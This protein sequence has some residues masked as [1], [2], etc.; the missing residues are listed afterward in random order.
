MPK[1]Q[2]RTT[3]LRHITQKS[4][5]LVFGI[6]TSASSLWQHCITSASSLRQHC[7]T[8]ASSLRQHCIT[9]A[10]SLWQ[11]CITSASSLWQHCITSASSLWQHCILLSYLM[12]A[13][14]TSITSVHLHLVTRRHT[15]GD[16]SI[17][18]QWHCKLRPQNI[19][20]KPFRMFRS[21]GP[22]PID[23]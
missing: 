19:V 2:Q 13:A 6:F 4:E 3:N 17:H 22:I 20:V 5:G 16:S 11:H 12:E 21:T 15:T 14:A 23:M 7:I 18:R 8:S 1:R 9:S 10:S